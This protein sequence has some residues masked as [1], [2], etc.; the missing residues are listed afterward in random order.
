MRGTADAMQTLGFPWPSTV[1]GFARTRAGMDE[2]GVFGMTPDAAR[3]IEV[4][5]PWLVQCR[6]D[7]SAR[8]WYAPAPR[9]AVWFAEEGD[10]EGLQRVRVSPGD[11][12]GSEQTD[13]EELEILRP[14]DV[15]PRRSRCQ[16][17][18]SIPPRR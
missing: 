13:L 2:H 6:S 1:A 4:R 15:L 3:E 18:P 10:P 12:S 17:P 8:R 16:V 9:D 7:G 14:L 5:G 11:L